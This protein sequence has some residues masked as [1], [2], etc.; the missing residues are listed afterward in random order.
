MKLN[1]SPSYL[2]AADTGGTFTDVVAFDPGTGELRYCKTLTVYRDLVEGVLQGVE[3]AGLAPRQLQQMKHGTT[4]I[5][6]TFLQRTGARTALA[7]TRGFRDAIEIARGSRPVPFSLKFR[8]LPPLVPRPW[9][10]ELGGRIDARGNET[11]PLD[12][13]EIVS[14]AQRLREDSIEAVAV[15]F[16]NAYL[17]PMHEQEAADRLRRLLPG[18]FVTTGSEFSREWYEYERSATAIAN[19]Y[20]GPTMSWYLGRFETQLAERGFGGR[21]FMMGSNGGVLTVA[22][23]QAQPVALVESGPIGGCIGA[24]VMARELG[25]ANV[26]ALDMGGTTAKCSVI[27]DGQLQIEPFYYVGGYDAG[28]PIRSPVLDVVEVGTGGGSIAWIDGQKRLRVGPKSAGSEPGPVCFG[29]GGA[30]P[31]ITD[32]DLILGRIGAG[33]FLGGELRLDEAGALHALSERVGTPLGYRSEE[34]LDRLAQGILTIAIMSMAE[35][36]KRITVERGR[37]PRDFELYV[38]GG[39]GPLHGTALARELHIP[40]VVVP[41]KPGNFSAIGMLLADSR[42]DDAITYVSMLND[43]SVQRAEELF[44][45]MENAA[46]RRLRADFGAMDAEIERQ[47]ELRFKGQRHCLR[48]RMEP[49]T[50]AQA[51]KALF[52]SSYRKRFGHLG[53]SGGIEFVGVRVQASACATGVGARQLFGAGERAQPAPARERRVYFGELGKRVVTPVYW[54]D[55]LPTGFRA[56]GP[57]IVEEYGSTTVAGPGDTFE[58]GS[59][60]EIRL[61]CAPSTGARS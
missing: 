23:A 5:I 31:T 4:H 55:S 52:E 38:F 54:R 37:D 60:G 61:R 45:G 9:R 22:G 30:E 48:V 15:S 50:N 57:A 39:G 28:F 59:L 13:E 58:I 32:T 53:A 51:L 18:V 6:N 2:L 24:A 16:L 35:A 26:I 14:L 7:T 11:E 40:V 44:A 20:V 36:I 27:D 12:L 21:C 17:N 25:A 47:V 43:A 49:D 33:S 19:A 8:K 29:R 56:R 1:D 46:R 34:E 42:I 10:F 3:K 41:P